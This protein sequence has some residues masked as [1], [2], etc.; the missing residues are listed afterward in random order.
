MA[1]TSILIGQSPQGPQRLELKRANRH[2]LVAGA[3]G[4]GKT[5]TLQVLAESFS[6]A[7]VP[8]FAADVK[9]DL[10]GVAAPSDL[11]PR[12]LERAKITGPEPLTAQ[13]S[14]VVFWDLYGDQGHPIRTTITE[15]GP[16]LLGRILDL[17][18]A[19]EG[20]LTIVFKLADDWV[21]SK[22]TDGLLLNLADLRAILTYVADNDDE[23]SKTYGLISKQT[24]AAI[25]RKLL[26]IEMDGA[27]KF[28]GEPALALNDLIRT[29][30]DGRGVINLLA[31][32]KL[33]QSPR[34]YAMVLLWLMSELWEELPEV[35]DLDKP[36]L[37]FFFDEAH[38]LFKDAPKPL[39]DRIEQVARLIRSK[40]VGVY[41]ITQSPADIPDPVLAQLG[42]RVQHALRAYTPSD[43]KA[44]KAAAQGFRAAD[45][46]D[47]ARAIQ[48]CG[49][50]EALVSTLDP[51]G[52]PTPVART[53]IRPP[54]SL[55][56]PIPAAQRQAIIAACEMGLKYRETIDRESAFERLTER[57]EDDARAAEKAAK[58]EAEAKERAK[59]DTA[60][61][62]EEA[63]A[64]AQRERQRA[65]AGK[66]AGRVAT[67]VTTN[68]LTM[69]GREVVRGIFGTGRRRR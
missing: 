42:N 66:S 20:A 46:M 40:G 49:V 64:D 47:V 43:Q 2:G 48:E 63:R 54:A 52:A 59:R 7:G 14:P 36:R 67:R 65:Q 27:D 32:D 45:G 15:M 58:D 39:L 5:V 29:T 53:L 41:F 18:E 1:E 56:G 68:V 17:S 33:I 16:L 26:Q 51:K 61:D 9:G 60:R 12:W 8:V 37:V 10:S 50:G 62:K 34:L 28:F 25:Q 57:A 38:L 35:G 55:V 22:K 69:L 30:A 13:A 21:K 24:I 11:H 31:A 6:A 3:T 23:I 19:Q 44:L 4:T